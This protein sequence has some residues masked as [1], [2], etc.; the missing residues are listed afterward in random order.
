LATKAADAA[1]IA[2]ASFEKYC[3]PCHRHYFSENAYV[4]HL[5]SQKHKQNVVKSHNYSRQRSE[6][7]VGSVI[8]ST[9]SLG[10]PTAKPN[11]ST[12]DE[13]DEISD[14]AEEE[15]EKVVSGIKNTSLDENDPISR[16]P[17]RPHASAAS[18]DLP[19]HPLSPAIKSG[20]EPP[21]D[22]AIRQCLFCNRYSSSLESNVAHMK[23]AHDLFIPE[24]R[25]LVDLTGLIS[26]LSKKVHEDNQCLYCNR[27]KWS[28][29]GIKTHM[30]DISHCKIAYE[31]EDEQL[32][33]GEYYDFRSTYSDAGDEDVEMGGAERADSQD[34]EGEDGWE[35]S[36]TVSSVPTEELGRMYYDDDRD[37]GARQ[38]KLKTH[39]HH[40]HNNLGKH[41]AA[42]GWHSHAHHTTYAVYHDEVELHLPTGR[43]AG[44][45]SLNKYWRQNL[46]NYPTPEERQQRL[47][48]GADEREAADDMD[49]DS[50][51]RGRTRGRE[52]QVTRANGGLGMLTVSDSKKREVQVQEKK[53]RRREGRH[54][55]KMQ[56]KANK[57]GNSQKHFRDPL[58]Q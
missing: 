31:S 16:R 36:S 14:E 18:K 29:S 48:A 42:D 7:E 43:I 54:N 56:W 52:N 11:A 28:E 10:E 27:F 19:I 41:R 25:Y 44:H 39:R 58:L 6:P 55:A 30:R 47:L 15:F 9:F 49:I 22:F 23:K 21:K 38:E 3:E 20:V 24:R 17:S 46:R 45:R 35:T 12:V 4:N 33:I 13:E 34:G 53:D 57:I 32:E 40:T 50:D 1:T 37:P 2:K 8:S 51:P 5:A 26:Y